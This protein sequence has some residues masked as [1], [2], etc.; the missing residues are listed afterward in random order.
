MKMLFNTWRNGDLGS[1]VKN[2]I[3]NNFKIISKYFKRLVM[4]LPTD[5]IKNL[6]TV[7][8]DKGSRIFDSTLK[9]WVEFNGEKWIECRE[10][11]YIY[12]FTGDNWI[13]N[14]IT[15]P[16]SEHMVSTP[17]VQLFMLNAGKYIPVLGSISIDTD[18]N[19]V[20]STD[21]IFEGRVVIR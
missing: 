21:M 16:Y 12:D 17:N 7:Y 9:R 13:N 14:T 1:V 19:I 15:L 3:D 11:E 10:N 18:Y 5:E 4:S 20:L 6:S 8:Y 2:I